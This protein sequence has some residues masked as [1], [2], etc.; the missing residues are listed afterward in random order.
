MKRNSREVGVLNNIWHLQNQNT[1]SRK[2]KL[3]QTVVVVWVGL[4][5]VSQVNFNM[6]VL[7]YYLLSDLHR[8]KARSKIKC[9]I[10]IGQKVLEAV[11][12]DYS[13]SANRT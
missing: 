7:I 8:W 1:F 2:R 9:S 12:S 4:S 6:R 3:I 10:R 5:D 11:Y 13:V